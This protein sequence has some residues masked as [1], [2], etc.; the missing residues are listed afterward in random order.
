M[1]GA[2]AAG[3]AVGIVFFLSSIH[4]A[5]EPDLDA[6]GN[7]IRNQARGARIPFAVERFKKAVERHGKVSDRLHDTYHRTKLD[8]LQVLFHAIF[9]GTFCT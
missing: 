5:I 8:A 2:V 1:A 3:V 9:I 6:L 4:E 7:A